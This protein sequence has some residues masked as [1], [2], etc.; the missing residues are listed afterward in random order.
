M[1]AVV[2]AKGSIRFVCSECY[3]EFLLSSSFASETVTCPECLHV[4]KRP[5]DDFLRTVNIH[6]SGERKSFAAVTL[7]GLLLLVALVSLLWMHSPYCDLELVSDEAT[8]SNMSLALMGGGAVLGILF[9][10]LLSRFESNRWEV[11]F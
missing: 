1:P 11:Y 10:W 4:G 8:R 6:K 9:F 7:V 5:D 3:E 2:R